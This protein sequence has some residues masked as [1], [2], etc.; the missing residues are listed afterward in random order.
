VLLHVTAALLL[1]TVLYRALEWLTA[2][3]PTLVLALTAL[4]IAAALVVF[5]LLLA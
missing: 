5:L 3:A 4:G 2:K 1:L